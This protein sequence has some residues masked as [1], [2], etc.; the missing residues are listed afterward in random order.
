LKVI[1]YLEMLRLR[2]STGIAVL[3]K[4]NGIP[5]IHL[6]H[7]VVASLNYILVRTTKIE[8]EKRKSGNQEKFGRMEQ[9]RRTLDGTL[10]WVGIVP[11]CQKFYDALVTWVT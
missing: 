1:I 4:F 7:Y 6:P 9:S 3:N 11:F 10:R 5:S 8:K 2:L